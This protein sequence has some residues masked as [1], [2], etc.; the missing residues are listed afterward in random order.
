MK[1]A[2]SNIA[3]D[4]EQDAEVAAI[5]NALQV[6]GVEIAPTKIWPKPLEAGAPAIRRYRDFWEQ[7]GIR[8]VAMQALLF[9]RPDLTIFESDDRRRETLGYLGGMIRLGQQLGAGA[10]V[11]GSPKNRR[12]GNLSKPDARKIAVDFFGELGDLAFEHDTAVCIEPNP[13]EYGCDFINNTEEAVALVLETGSPGFRVHIDAG[14]LAMN[15]EDP[16]IAI[17]RALPLT[18]HFHISEPYL[19]PIGANGTD[20]NACAATLARL[21]YAHWVSIEMRKPDTGGLDAVA[22]AL[23]QSID[24]YSRLFEA[25]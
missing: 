15:H 25:S 18:H 8:I 24:S 13:A 21:R 6:S 11:F 2:I 9:G 17:S 22:A 3:W 5:L 1:L 16:E 23:R 14:A 10:L 7:N 19:G 20:H 12:V 4:V